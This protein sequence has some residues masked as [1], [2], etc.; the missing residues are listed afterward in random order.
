MQFIRE[1]RSIAMLIL[2][3]LSDTLGLQGLERFVHAHRTDLPSTSSA[4]LQYY[5]HQSNLSENMSTG[6]FSHTDTGSLT[7]LFTSEWGL[8]VCSADDERWEY[9]PPAMD[10]RVIVNVGDSLKFMSGNKLKSCLHRVVPCY[11]KWEG[12]GRFST[13]YF[14]RPSN[15]TEFVDSEGRLWRAGDWLDS[16]FAIYRAPHSEQRTTA[17][18]TGRKG[19]VGLWEGPV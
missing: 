12:V 2:N 6:I 5:P 11:G 18:V 8:Q 9:V 17:M 14:C 10:D 13:I 19:F 7:I 1:S 3:D 16:K 15:D 4:A